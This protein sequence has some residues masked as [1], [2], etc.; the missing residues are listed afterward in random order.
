MKNLFRL[1]GIIALAAVIGFSFVALSLTGCD[2]GG[3]GGTGGGD[4]LADQLSGTWKAGNET[5]TLINGSFVITQ[6]DKPYGRGTYTASARSISANISLAVKELHGDILTEEMKKEG[7]NKTFESRW[8]TKE[9]FIDAF[10]K[11]LKELGASDAEANAYIN[12]HSGDLN[13]MY[14][15]KTGTIDGDT[16]TFDGTTYTKTAGGN[17]T[18]T[19][20]GDSTFGR[21]DINAIAYGNNTFVAMLRQLAAK[22]SDSKIPRQ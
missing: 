19:A 22:V 9:Q 10:K 14:P 2:N 11:I 7:I 8:H 4:P 5:G 20:A 1:S 6:N 12:Q 13:A 21:N 15:T 3:G 17:M 18:W 16:M